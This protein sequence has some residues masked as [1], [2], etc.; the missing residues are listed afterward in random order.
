MHIPP[1]YSPQ[2]YMSRSSTSNISAVNVTTL[3]SHT[4]HTLYLAM[5]PYPQWICTENDN[6]HEHNRDWGI[7]AHVFLL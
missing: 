4:T 6:C 3:Y 5:E 7:S 1:Y 2:L